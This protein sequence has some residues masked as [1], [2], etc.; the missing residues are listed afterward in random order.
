MRRRGGAAGN[1]GNGDGDAA[2]AQAAG[3][4][5]H[6]Q[7]AQP[8]PSSSSS[9]KEKKGGNGGHWRLIALAVGC[10]VFYL[11]HAR[12]YWGPPPSFWASLKRAFWA[13]KKV[14]GFGAFVG[15]G[16]AN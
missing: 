14:V 12:E 15:S 9:K 10:G 13:G 11:S 8:T 1:G 7:K 3:A 16:A 6:P 5:N 2:A 4:D